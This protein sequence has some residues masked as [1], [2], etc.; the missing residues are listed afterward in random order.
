MQSATAGEFSVNLTTG[1]ITGPQ[2]YLESTSYQETKRKIE[3]GTHVLITRSP[4]G[5]PVAQLVAVILQTDYA[6]WLGMQQTM[7]TLQR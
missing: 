6:A 1:Q 3:N 5:I 7:A 4:S 2:G